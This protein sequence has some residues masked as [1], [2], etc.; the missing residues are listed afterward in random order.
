MLSHTVAVT[1]S[2]LR[3]TMNCNRSLFFNTTGVYLLMAL[4]CGITWTAKQDKLYTV[5]AA[6]VLII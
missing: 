6:Q 1:S 4:N 2:F 3:Q 5:L